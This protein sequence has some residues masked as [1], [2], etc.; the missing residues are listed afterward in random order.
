MNFHF[1][2]EINS[3]TKTWKLRITFSKSLK[4]ERFDLRTA[5]ATIHPFYANYE[6]RQK[7]RKKNTMIKFILEV[8]FPERL[9]HSLEIAGP[10]YF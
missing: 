10:I 6:K 2:Y 4:N 7:E 1:L 9:E 3:T 5:G 8:Q